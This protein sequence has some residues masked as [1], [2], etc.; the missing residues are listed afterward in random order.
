MHSSLFVVRALFTGSR[1]RFAAVVPQKVAKTAVSRTKIRR[2]IYE[3]VGLIYV[4]VKQPVHVI[5]MAK[6]PVLTA[7]FSDIVDDLK[8]IFVKVGIMK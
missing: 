2:K 4:E 1:A 7:P 3:A 5:I 8:K 6:T